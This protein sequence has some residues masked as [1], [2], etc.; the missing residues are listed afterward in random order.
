[1]YCIIFYISVISIYVYDYMY[2][3]MDTYISPGSY[4]TRIHTDDYLMGMIYHRG[5]QCGFNL[6]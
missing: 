1:M 2:V 3:C 6:G 5:M 4:K